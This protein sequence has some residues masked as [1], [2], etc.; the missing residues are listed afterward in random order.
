[1]TAPDDDYCNT[2]DDDSRDR[3]SHLICDG[4]S[5]RHLPVTLSLPVS[6]QIWIQSGHWA[7]TRERIL[8]WSGKYKS[9]DQQIL[10]I[11]LYKVVVSVRWLVWLYVVNRKFQFKRR[12]FCAHLRCN[13]DSPP[14]VPSIDNAQAEGP[15]LG[16]INLWPW[17]ILM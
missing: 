15:E 6:R 17:L 7:V 11:C 9:N 16:L 3:G 8:E 12:L 10:Y 5:A 2:S 1:M 4:L 14:R 13:S